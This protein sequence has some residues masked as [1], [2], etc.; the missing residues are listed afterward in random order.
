MILLSIDPGATS[1]TALFF[2]G[3]LAWSWHGPISAAFP[4]ALPHITQ[5]VIE[6]PRHYPHS[7]KSD[8]KTGRVHHVD[9]N[10]LITLAVNVGQWVERV[11]MLYGVTATT[12]LPQDWKRQ[13]SKKIAHDR[14]H[15]VLTPAER[16]HWP[17]DHN[18]RDAIGIGLHALGRW[19][20]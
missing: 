10:T 13:L 9:P 18:A 20:V 2:D 4:V 16:A 5:V 7:S 12:V 1:G 3:S 6:K 11:R 15:G 17:T 19:R 14:I 8:P